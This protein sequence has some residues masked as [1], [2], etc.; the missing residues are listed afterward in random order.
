MVEKPARLS[1]T[2]LNNVPPSIRYDRQGFTNDAANSAD[3]M[4][5]RHRACPGG[6]TASA[7][8]GPLA[9]NEPD[10]ANE[11][12]EVVQKPLNPRREVGGVVGMFRMARNLEAPR[13]LATFR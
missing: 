10:E 12:E 6:S 2:V 13:G 5:L 11:P 7:L 4:N 9:A 8:L 1:L 3:P